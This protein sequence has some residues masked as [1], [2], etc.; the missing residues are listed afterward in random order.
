MYIES[1][2]IKDKQPQA[3]AWHQARVN[4]TLQN[5]V[6]I[7]LAKSIVLPSTLTNDIYKCRVVYNAEKIQSIEFLL[8]KPLI[9]KT[10]AFVEDDEIAY[11]SKYQRRT[12]LERLKQQTTADEVIIVKN[13]WVTDTSYSNLVFWDGVQWHT[14]ITYLLNGTMRQRLLQ[15]GK[16]IESEIRPSDMSKFKSLKLINAML[17][18]ESSL[19]VSVVSGLKFRV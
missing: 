2:Q 16:I 11:S 7:D 10:L 9:I 4:A 8:Y 6:S 14:P 18:L 13:G 19:D 15:E 3:L 5:A 17:D 1:I 12:D